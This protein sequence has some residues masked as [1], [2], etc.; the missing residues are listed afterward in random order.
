MFANDAAGA[1]G[2]KGGIKMITFSDLIAIENFCIDL[3]RNFPIIDKPTS[4]GE[5]IENI[6]YR[7]MLDKIEY[8][9]EDKREEWNE[10]TKR[11]EVYHGQ[12]A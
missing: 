8:L 9:L 10:Q 1:G 6:Y 2:M 12:R 3:K 11:E 4:K 5:E 7:H